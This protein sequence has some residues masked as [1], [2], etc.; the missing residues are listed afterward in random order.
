MSRH[1]R[2]AFRVAIAF[3]AFLAVAAQARTV[4]GVTSGTD[5]AQTIGAVKAVDAD[6]RR[7]SV[8]TG[9]GH[10][11]RVMV[12]HAGTECRIEVGGVGASLASLRRGQIV[13]VWHREDAQRHLAERIETLAVPNVERQR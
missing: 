10:A 1:A 3:A 2:T 9:C 11:L 4:T 8:I 13:A 6:V 12:F 5:A 7:I